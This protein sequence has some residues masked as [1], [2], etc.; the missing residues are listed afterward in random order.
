MNGTFIE[1][2][3][4]LFKRADEAIALAHDPVVRREYAM[5]KTCL[6]DAMMRWNRGLAIELGVFTVADLEKSLA[7]EAGAAET[8][9][10]T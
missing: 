8:I 7:Y 4:A 9:P 5:T 1:N 6:E 3:Q 10:G 2:A